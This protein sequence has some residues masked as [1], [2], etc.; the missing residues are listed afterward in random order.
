MSLTWTARYCIVDIDAHSLVA[1]YHQPVCD[2]QQ[3]NMVGNQTIEISNIFLCQPSPSGTYT[4]NSLE[5]EEDDHMSDSQQTLRNRR[6]HPDKQIRRDSRYETV[7]MNDCI[8][9]YYATQTL[10]NRRRNTD[11]DIRTDGKSYFVFVFS[12]KLNNKRDALQLYF[13]IVMYSISQ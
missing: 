3:A 12:L 2:D 5:E 13:S 1:L 8:R 11:V 4:S 6:Y 10:P 7:N 9:Q